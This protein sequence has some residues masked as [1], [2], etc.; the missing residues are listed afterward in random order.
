M[1]ARKGRNVLARALPA[2]L[3]V[4]LA[5]AG[6]GGNGDTDT[7]QGGG[8]GEGSAGG[9][10]TELTVLLPFP[11]GINFY[12]LFVAQERGY[13][14]NDVSI[15]V[16]AADGSGAA[17]QQLLTGNA[18]VCMCGPGTALRAVAKG[19]DLLSLYTLYQKDVFSL[20]APSD[21]PVQSVEDL[22]GKTI[23]VD[24]RE[25][26][27]ESWLVPLMSSAGMELGQDYEVTAVGPGAA[28]ITAFNGDTIQAYA[29]A[30]VD[31]A[32]LRLRGFELE[33]VDIPGSDIFFDSGV[34][35]RADFVEENPEVVESFGR[36][37]AMA[38]EWGMANPE[39]VLE[40]TSENYPEEAEERDFALALLKE[41][42]DLYELPE[43]ADDRWG[44]TPPE[45]ASAL[46]DALH[47][48]GALEAEV[49]PSVF[50]NDYVD[51]YNDFEESDL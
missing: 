20:V 6:C 8:G 18:D 40:I 13:F 46:A 11:S 9:S 37:L 43:A 50:K 39:G 22:R 33:Q 14:G 31:H 2:V 25:G 41:T 17:L 47:E 16:E 23:G 32:I 19:E 36:G 42:N 51:A 30:F 34:W 10:S 49:D 45:R 27:A 1:A 3:A 15:N 12:P 7:A 26:G 21:S 35:M 48:Q 4:A 5:A 38:T 24:A 44:Y 28:P 29:G